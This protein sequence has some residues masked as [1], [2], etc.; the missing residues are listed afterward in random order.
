MKWFRKLFTKPCKECGEVKVSFW[1]KRCDFCDE[2]EGK[3]K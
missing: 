2:D 1:K 3:V